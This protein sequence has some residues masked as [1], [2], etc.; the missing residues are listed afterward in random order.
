MA[1]VFTLAQLHDI[2]GFGIAGFRK[3]HQELIFVRFGDP[4]GGR[5]LLD[6][7][8]SRAASAWE[9]GTFNEVFSEVRRRSHAE[10]LSATWVGV[11]I[12]AAGYQALG[13]ATTGLPA[14]EGT[15]AFNAGMASR[16]QQTGD[17][18][19]FDAP[20]GWLAPFQPG[21]GV[22]MCVVI[23][24]DETDDLD[25]AVAAIGDQ[26]SAHGCQVVFQER[27]RTLPPPLTGHEHFGFKDG[28]SQPAIDGYSDS[29][30]PNE[31]PA[32][33]AGEF[34][35]G[36]ANSQG[37]PLQLAGSLWM[38]GS[39]AVFRRLCQDVAAFRAQSNA[40]V[41]GS[42]PALTS[43]QTAATLVGRWPSGAPLE[44]NPTVDPGET[45][46][47]NAFQYKADPFTDDDGHN[48]SH[49]AHVRKV[50][51]RDETTPTP[52]TDNPQFHRMIRRGI[53]FGSPLAAGDADGGQDRGL[54]F[55]CV[56]SDLDRQFEFIQRQWLDDPAFPGGLPGPTPGSYSP[57]TQGLPDGPDPI[58]GENDA[59]EECLLIQASGQHP[60][61]I[62]AQLVRTTAGEYFFVPSLSALTAIA[63][64]ITQ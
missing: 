2:Q 1:D 30:Q 25:E 41:V 20:P 8:G 64:G 10:T 33:P 37:E 40:G 26:V 32:V 63:A 54:H 13:V 27:G 5:Q 24:A 39:F 12:S 48:C 4:A 15:N 49:F 21:A 51:P 3:D 29:P 18:G 52:D 34:V 60:F 53:P 43:D 17:T 58:A 14:G 31:P 11:L 50:N 9:V 23:A 55:L 28:I 57:P 22:H 56:V 7:L 45:G 6:W 46:I 19:Q 16:S 47:T 59:G 42:A 38:N 36:Y 35:L 62:T 61:P 44:L